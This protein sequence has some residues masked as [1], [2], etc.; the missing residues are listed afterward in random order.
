MEY[1]V[2]MTNDC[3]LHCQYCSVLLDC[4]AN[5]LPVKPTYSFKDLA[6]F[7]RDVQVM[8][9]D[10][11][12]SVYFF[13]GEPSLE[14]SDILLLTHTLD[15]EL[16]EYKISYVLHTNGLLLDAIPDK[17]LMQLKLIMFSI[18]YEKIPKYNL[19]EGYYKTITTNALTTKAKRSIPII[20]RLTITEN[21]SLYTEILQTAQYFDYIYWQIE[22]C[23]HFSDFQTFYET[24]SFEIGET[25]RY[26][27]RLLHLGVLL[28]YVPFMAVLKFIFYPDRNDDEFSCG[29]SRGMIYIQTDGSCY[30]CSDSVET[31]NHLVGTIHSEVRLPKYKLNRFRCDKCL[32]RSI[33]MG[34]CGRMHIEFDATHISEYCKLNRYMFDLFLNDKS[35]LDD[36]LHQ[37]PYL[38]EELEDELLEYTEFTP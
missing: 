10:P 2:Y 14:Y 7:I 15:S 1:F 6:G 31:K 25:Y 11:N 13:G 18:N 29:Y 9:N 5:G 34:R 24:Y 32:Y 19:S 37:F 17:L 3:N 8:E 33:C 20:G 28:R 35:E 12:I 36:I 21:T 26:W 27:K 30:A 38:R 23:H 16:P 4:K 22:N